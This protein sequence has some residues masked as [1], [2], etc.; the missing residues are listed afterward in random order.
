MKRISSSRPAS[1]PSHELSV[2]DSIERAVAIAADQPATVAPNGLVHTWRQVYQRTASLAAGLLALGLRPGDR[3]AVALP[4]HPDY[5]ECF[6]ACAMAGLIIAP[7]NTRLSPEELSRYIDLIDPAAIITDTT[8]AL[9]IRA[10]NNRIFI[11]AGNSDR[12]DPREGTVLFSD[13]LHTDPLHT[14]IRRSED[15][16]AAL[17]S[18]GGTTGTPRAVILTSRNL[19]T[20]AYHVQMSLN[21][22]STD[23][24]LHAAPMFHVADC[25]SLFAITLVGGSHAFLPAFSAGGFGSRL[26]ATRSTATLLVPTMVHLLLDNAAVQAADLSSWRLLFYGGAPM[27]PATLSQA[28]QQLPCSFAQGYGMTELSLATVLGTDDHNPQC[29]RD[30]RDMSRLRS[31]GRPAPGVKVRVSDC[32]SDGVGE[33]QVSGPNTFAGYWRDLNTT[34]ATFTADGWVRTGDLG[35]LDAD[36][37][38]HLVDRS[39][40]M[41]ITGGENV[42]ST[43]VEYA[44][45]LHQ[46]VAEVAVIGLPDPRWGERVHA[47]VV[48]HAASNATITAAELDRFARDHLATYKT[49]RSYEFVDR[50]PKTGPGKINK[51]ELRKSRINSR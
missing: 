6:Y 12:N 49:P 43:E 48:P 51:K 4:N 36:G 8:F 5:L 33:V 22:R 9:D 47:V 27:S 26:E 46:S 34:V 31:A 13:L 18:T 40:D 44:L 20:N 24:Y 2:L 1:V 14:P 50:L 30:N 41:I 32:A 35:F 16:P 10:Q 11:L 37:Y 23:R 3:L 7:L 39:K 28:M 21:Y 29:G 38:L 25:A 17:F 45:A 42:Y 15:E 19:V